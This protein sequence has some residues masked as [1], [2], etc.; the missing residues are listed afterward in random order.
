MLCACEMIFARR[1]TNLV[2]HTIPTLSSTLLLAG[3]TAAGRVLLITALVSTYG[4]WLGSSFDS[5]LQF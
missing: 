4:S 3:F 1:H 2:T 5:Q